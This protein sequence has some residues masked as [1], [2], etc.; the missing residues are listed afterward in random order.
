MG[1]L[2]ILVCLLAVNM[3]PC[4]S[5]LYM[6]FPPGSNNRLNGANENVQNNARLFDSQV[7]RPFSKLGL[8]ASKNDS[9][10]HNKKK[11]LTVALFSLIFFIHTV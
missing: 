2:L 3:G 4:M 6:H 10:S 1:K 7:G 5:D 9:F 11:V 8:L